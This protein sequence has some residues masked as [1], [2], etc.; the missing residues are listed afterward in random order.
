MHLGAT[1]LAQVGLEPSAQGGFLV[2]VEPSSQAQVGL[3][4]S[5]H[6]LRRGLQKKI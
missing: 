1:P 4:L 2:R 3:V 5:P 6:G